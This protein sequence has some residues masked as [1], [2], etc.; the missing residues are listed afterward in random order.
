MAV[1]LP[2]EFVC[3]E[4]RPIAGTL[5]ASAMARGEPG[6]PRRFFWRKTEYEMVEV[7]KRWKTT[8]PCTSGSDESYVRR[9]WY[10]IVTRPSA[11]MTVYFDRRPKDRRH[12]K[13]R[14]WVYSA[15]LSSNEP[16]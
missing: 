16:Q 4:M 7:V 13:A 6:L 15:A 1:K 5:D 12:P 2:E 8:G 11:V 10:R 3:E 9:H 14:W